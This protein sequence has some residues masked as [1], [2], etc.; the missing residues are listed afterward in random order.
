VGNLPFDFSGR[1]VVVS[2]L[3]LLVDLKAR[4]TR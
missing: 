2:A 3:T 1:K 4:E